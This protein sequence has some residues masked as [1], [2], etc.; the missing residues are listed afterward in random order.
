MGGSGLQVEAVKNSLLVDI[1]DV[2]NEPF[3]DGF[4]TFD[5]D[6]TFLYQDDAEVVGASDG[7]VEC[8]R[9]AA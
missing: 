4:G 3:C 2:K 9:V 1:S 6:D 8:R 5:I 7:G